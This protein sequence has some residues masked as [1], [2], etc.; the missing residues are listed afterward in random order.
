MYEEVSS[1]WGCN[2]RNHTDVML[3][4]SWDTCSTWMVHVSCQ[5][6]THNIHV[7]WV[8]HTKDSCTIAQGRFMYN[9]TRK[10]MCI[11]RGQGVPRAPLTAWASRVQSEGQESNESHKTFQIF[12]FV[13]SNRSLNSSLGFILPIAIL[14][15]AVE[16]YT[17]W[18]RRPWQ[19]RPLHRTES[20]PQPTPRP[21]KKKQ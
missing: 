13:L 15:Q 2:A 3:W 6:A 21:Q 10:I 4:F 12:C 8:M 14:P 9:R 7:R 18:A 19:H 20:D 16:L 1:Q 11:S 5:N 17:P